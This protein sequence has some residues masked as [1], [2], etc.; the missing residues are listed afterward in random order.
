MNDRLSWKEKNRIANK[1]N[2]F[3]TV[4]S[5]DRERG[6]EYIYLFIFLIVCYCPYCEEIVCYGLWCFLGGRERKDH[7]VIRYIKNRR[8]GVADDDSAPIEHS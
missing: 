7:K 8:G 6:W 4:T 1:R 3:C 2:Y 5:L